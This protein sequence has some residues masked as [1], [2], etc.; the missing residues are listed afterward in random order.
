M[1]SKSL[2]FFFYMYL[3]ISMVPDII[4]GFHD[5]VPQT[6]MPNTIVN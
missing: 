1:S 5:I 3:A 4:H 6:Y 2:N